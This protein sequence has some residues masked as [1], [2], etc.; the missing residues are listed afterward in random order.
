MGHLYT[1]QI[2]S[3]CGKH[4]FGAQLLEP[5]L[6]EHRRLGHQHAI[7]QGFAT[8]G[9]PSHRCQRRWSSATWRFPGKPRLLGSFSAAGGRTVTPGGPTPALPRPGR[10]RGAAEHEPAVGCGGARRART[11]GAWAPS[12]QER[13]REGKGRAQQRERSGL[14]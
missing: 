6:P 8:P 10:A 1:I 7:Q 2:S 5:V 11:A 4:T 3:L 14:T 13:F 12:R 9:Q